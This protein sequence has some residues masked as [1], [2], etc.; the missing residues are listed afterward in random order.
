MKST[1]PTLSE[2]M[3]DPESHNYICYLCL[4]DNIAINSVKPNIMLIK[5]KNPSISSVEVR[6]FEEI[7]KKDYTHRVVSL[8]LYCNAQEY[9]SFKHFLGIQMKRFLVGNIEATQKDVEKYVL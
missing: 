1:A 2:R 7:T 4:K 9:I 3:S 8:L 6:S 5:K